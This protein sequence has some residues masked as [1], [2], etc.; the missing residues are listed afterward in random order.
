MRVLI[1]FEIEVGGLGGGESVLQGLV[2]G[3]AS[4]DPDGVQYDILCPEGVANE[5]RPWLSNHIRTI[6]RPTAKASAASLVKSAAAGWRR[7]LGKLW[8]RLTG[9]PEQG[10]PTQTPQLDPFIATLP[11][12]VLH[13]MMPLHYAR[14]SDRAVFTIHDLQHEHLP[15]IFGERQIAYRRMLYEDVVTDC[16]AVVAIS[17]FTAQ[18]FQKHHR[19]DSSKLFAVPW[20][21]YADSSADQNLTAEEKQTIASLPADFMLYP[22]YSYRHKN[23]V[24]LLRALS[25]AVAEN[26]MPLICTG[27]RSDE[28][29]LIEEQWNLLKP[30]PQM[31]H[32]GRVSRG[33]LSELFR[34]SR[35]VVFPTLFEGAGLPLLEAA[36]AGKAIACSDIPPFREFGGSGPS[37]FDPTDPGSMATVLTRLWQDASERERSSNGTAAA[38]AH[39]SWEACARSYRAIYRKV[40]GRKLSEAD[41][42]CLKDAQDACLQAADSSC[43]TIPS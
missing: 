40:A 4:L 3:L 8:R 21:A 33:L 20:A 36:R 12:D 2:R 41:Q 10:L 27:G 18:D 39:L 34:R 37:Y 26:E 22:A 13:F 9:K 17:R 6:S 28:W 25:L 14:G 16:K 23:H 19:C 43:Q 30:R 38:S 1:L 35:F 7:P 5:L 31:Q 24:N 15:E 32:L 29:K 42:D 11:H